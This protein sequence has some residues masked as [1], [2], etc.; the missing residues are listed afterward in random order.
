MKIDWIYPDCLGLY[1]NKLDVFN[2]N[3][4]SADKKK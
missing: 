1:D 2:P 3:I 4:V